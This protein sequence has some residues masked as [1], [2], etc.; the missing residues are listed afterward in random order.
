MPAAPS[1]LAAAPASTCLRVR[2]TLRLGRLDEDEAAQDAVEIAPHLPVAQRRRDVLARGVQ[3]ARMAPGVE[4][5][6][7]IG[8]LVDVVHGRGD[9]GG[10]YLAGG[11]AEAGDRSAILGV[12][13]HAFRYMST[14][15][16][17]AQVHVLLSARR[18]E[19]RLLPDPAH[20]VATV[21]AH[22]VDV[23]PAAPDHAV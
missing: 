6:P 20:Q 14:V 8:V 17:A 22:F 13:V 3:R 19:S 23:V 11:V 16:I 2:R 12:G 15:R 1:A 9:A 10:A 21:A 5:V 18:A 7:L 4:H